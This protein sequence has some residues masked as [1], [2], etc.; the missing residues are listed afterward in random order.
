MPRRINPEF[1]DWMET[2]PKPVLEEH[3][4][5][6]QTIN[7]WVGDVDIRNIEGWQG[8]PRTELL[9]DQFLETFAREPT[10]EEMCQLALDDDDEKEGL[11]IK[12]LAANIQKNGVRVPIVLTHS[13]KLLDG[14]RR[15]Y[16]STFLLMDSA[17]KGRRDFSKIPALVLPEGTTQEIED[18]I[19][20]EFNFA[21]SMQLEWP[22][23]IRARRVFLDHDEFG[24]SKEE[25]T[26]KYGIPWRYLSKWVAAARLCDQFLSYHE[27]TFTA[28][29]FA[30]RNFIMF[31]E[32]ARNYSQRFKD[33]EFRRAIFE[34]LL[35]G[36]EPENHKHHKFTKS[37]D[38]IRLDEIYDHEDSWQALIHGRGDKALKE[39]LGILEMSS[40]SGS[41]DPNPAL[42]RIVKGLEKLVRNKN[43]GSADQELLQTFRDCSQQVPGGPIDPATQIEQ[44]VDWL[45]AMSA[46]QIADLSKASVTRLKKALQIVTKFASTAKNAG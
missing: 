46:V 32:M 21:Q 40:L 28:K 16:A 18:A 15:Y 29:Q 24:F 5:H 37:A 25:L 26:R 3:R 11:K 44:M 9:R 6:D 19:L 43:L 22:Y 12:E 38:T 36:Y 13:K 17:K 45:E 8:N 14:N 41:N 33:G 2:N 39:A 4:F 42:K 1:P 35:S 31:D 34:V 30:F 20:T 10:D 23:Y 7:V 27:E